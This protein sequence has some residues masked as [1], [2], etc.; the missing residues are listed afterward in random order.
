MILYIVYCASSYCIIMLKQYK[1]VLTI[2][3]EKP[4]FKGLY[5]K[6]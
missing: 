4:N 1:Q 6:G 2:S 3:R 5:Y